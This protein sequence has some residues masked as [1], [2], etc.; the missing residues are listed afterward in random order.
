MLFFRV[1]SIN[2]NFRFD[3]LSIE[4]RAFWYQGSAFGQIFLLCPTDCRAEVQNFGLS[5]REPSRAELSN[6]P[7]IARFSLFPSPPNIPTKFTS[8]FL[9]L[10][11]LGS[12]TPLC[13]SCPSF[14]NVTFG[15]SELGR[16][17]P[18]DFWGLVRPKAAPRHFCPSRASA[19]RLSNRHWQCPYADPWSVLSNFT[20]VFFEIQHS[21][22]KNG[23]IVLI[24]P[25]YPVT[26]TRAGPG[27]SKTFDLQKKECSASPEDFFNRNAHERNSPKNL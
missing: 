9:Q 3:A 16:A 23:Q 12:S 8:C 26:L 11:S 21:K 25:Y 5:D 14:P 6:C 2:E 27:R 17:C 13:P 4:E 24:I 19:V 1:K 10:S 15:M 20:C 7:I 22:K 18:T